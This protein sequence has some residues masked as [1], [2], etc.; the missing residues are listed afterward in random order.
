MT[1]SLR[2]R[3][4]PSP[5][6]LLHLGNA[7]TALFNALAARGR[8]DFLLR[9]EDTDAERSSE[10][11]VEALIADLHW[12]GLDW[13]EG[14]RPM[15]RE[16]GGTGP[17]RQSARG[18]IYAGYYA[19]LEAAGLAYPC[20]CSP[21]QLALSRAAQRAAGQAP[22]YA[23]SCAHLSAEE[24]QARRDAGGRPTLRFRV[25]GTGEVGFH[26]RV[27]G[28]QRF[29]C[30]DIGDFIIRRADGTPAFFFCNAID[31]ALMGV[32]LVLRGD[33]HLTNTPRQLLI[34][35]ALG[36]PVPAYGHISLVLGEDGAPL[37]KRNGSRSLR[38]LRSQGYLPGA[39]LNQLGRLGHS[40]I[41]AGYQSLD[42]LAAGFDLA[43]LGRAP[44]RYDTEQLDHW[45]KEAVRAA[46]AA[47][48]WRWLA[49]HA[50]GLADRIP[51][52]REL[53]FVATVRDN[54][55]LPADALPWAEALYG[56]ADDF[57]TEA[58][59][60]LQAAGADW[61]AAA[62]AA[63]SGAEDFKP[64]TQAITAATGAR[65]KALFM[66]L[67]AALTG[68]VV[69]D[70]GAGHWRHGPELKRLWTLLGRDEIARRLA[71]ARAACAS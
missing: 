21:E 36:L 30:T 69:A 71:L 43:R 48:L 38:E 31:D 2:T 64:W 41:E 32:T 51:A 16:A 53:D 54:L 33:D 47:E 34:L 28:E 26:D 24:V 46:G 59:T 35:Q 62:A 23:G 55:L 56:A 6:G 68:A 12:L 9:I 70:A 65:G 67:R 29:R 8:G 20:F 44:A 40:Y 50:E 58:I 61:L 1:P 17:Y 42:Q 3:F 45:Q 7:R 15:G 60:E 37:S 39:L 14:P 22:R 52:G 18:A 5:T 27:R 49:G 11:H 19:R 66:P 25:P 10:A 63:L 57:D 13:D 4:A